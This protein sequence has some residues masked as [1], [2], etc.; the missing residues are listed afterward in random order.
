MFKSRRRLTIF[1]TVFI[2]LVA[3]PII[4]NRIYNFG[5]E[6]VSK[7]PQEPS[8]I[9]IVH[10]GESVVEIA[11]NLEKENLIKNALAFRL[12]IGRMGISKNIQAGDFRLSSAMPSRQIAQELTHGVLDVWVTLPEGLR[13]EE[14]AAKIEEKL[15]FGANDVYSFDKGEYIK[16]AEEGYMFPD[17][18]L[19]P[20]DATARQIAQKLRNTFDQKVPQ[21]TL[22]AGVKNDLTAKDIIILASLVEREAKTKDEK[23]TIAGILLNRIKAGMPLQVDATIQYALAYDSSQKT[24]WPQITI[25]QYTSVKSIYN[26]YLNPGLPP[27]PIA[28]PGLDSIL[29]AASPVD[30]NYY[31]YLHDSAGKIHYAET[32]QQ[33]N[34]NV[35]EFILNGNTPVFSPGI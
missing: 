8:Q 32:A 15:K 2:I 1:A 11:E 4:L 33:H 31:Y 3:T 23:P 16:T 20:K 21:E 29:A 30:N 13:L 35:K 7:N 6:P 17:T 22:E 5:L 12:L 25:D 27:A 24:W 28:S 18:Y 34:S 10:P 19:I 9:F 14:Q 26:T